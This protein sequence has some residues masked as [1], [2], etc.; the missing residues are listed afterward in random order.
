MTSQV[1]Q[2]LQL[3]LSGL[4]DYAGLFPPAGLDMREALWRYER[5]QREERGFALGRFVVQSHQLTEVP[6]DVP[7][8]VLCAPGEM[9]PRGD[10]LE[11]K[12]STEAEVEMI[13]AAQRDATVYVEVNDLNLL[14][15]VARNGLRAKIRTG[16]ITADAFPAVDKVAQ[17]ITGCYARGVPFK[18]TAGLHHPIRCDKPLTYEADAP[19]GTMHGFVNVF[20]AAMLPKQASKILADENPRSFAFDDG[21]LWW[22]DFRVTND[23]IA[24]VRREFAISFGSCSF[25]EPFVDLAELGWL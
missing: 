24:R 3:F 12:A 23:E 20:V 10:V 8:S 18:A 11:V 2:S 9:P 17:F 1:K 15:A 16:G 25:E 22:R 7:V 4:V 5:Y 19:S 6:D 14:D 21:G 13:A